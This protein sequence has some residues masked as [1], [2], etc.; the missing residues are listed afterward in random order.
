[1]IEIWMSPRWWK[2][3]E[4]SGNL[5]Q[6]GTTTNAKKPDETMPLD[7]CGPKTRASSLA[8]FPHQGQLVVV[9]GNGSL[10]L[11]KS[12]E[13]YTNAFG[14]VHVPL[15]RRSSIALGRSRKVVNFVSRLYSPL[16]QPDAPWQFRF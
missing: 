9:T 11:M 5:W 10:M 4:P 6:D 8:A 14:G 2:H 3:S 15:R 13:D 12:G 16:H 1:M 7:L